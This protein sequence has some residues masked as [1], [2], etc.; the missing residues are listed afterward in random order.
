MKHTIATKT[1][2]KVLLARKFSQSRSKC[3][4]GIWPSVFKQKE[5]FASPLIRKAY[6]IRTFPQC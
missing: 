2:C 6:T 3:N 4:W 1:E 5:T